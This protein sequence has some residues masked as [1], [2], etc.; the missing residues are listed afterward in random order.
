MPKDK[1]SIRQLQAILFS[2]LL[3]PMVLLLPQES[4]AVAGK[5]AWLTA[6]PALPITMALS[7][8][9]SA[10]MR[11]LPEGSGMAQ[12]LEYAFGKWPGRIVTGIY[13]LWGLFLLGWNG[14]WCGLRVLST[15][16]RNKPLPLVILAAVGITLWIGRKKLVAFARAGQVFALILGFAVGLSLLLGIF[17]MN[18]SNWG[19][20][21]IEDMGGV[22][23]GSIP[24]LGLLGYRV[25]GAF[26][27]G[28]MDCQKGGRSE[29]IKGS[30]LF[31]LGITVF[32]LVC[33]G[34]FGPELVKRMEIPYFMMV[35]GVGVP[36]AFQRVESLVMALWSLTDLALLG[37]L[38]FS[39]RKI[40]E[41]W[42]GG[43]GRKLIAWGLATV[44]MVLA[45]WVIPK[46]YN[47]AQITEGIVTMGN[48][49]LGVA[50]PLVVVSVICIR[51]KS[52]ERKK[53][54]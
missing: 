16:Y 26:L 8:G 48:L 14:W 6:L 5:A 42:T 34:N 47:I 7:W 41:D 37:L 52:D 32:Q 54:R 22:L 28:E 39:C 15:S 21:W 1:I 11:Y 50:L 30:A 46:A 31:C 43:K 35:T 9:F 51:G 18:A 33:I 13:F 3:S 12:G 25:F 49:I 19:P 10:S 29:L 2:A 4:V 45:L 53:G 24:V 40:I 36:G 38:F 17:K 23:R 44:T 20:V 27:G